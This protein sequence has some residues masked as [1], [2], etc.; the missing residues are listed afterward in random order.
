M[1][2]APLGPPTLRAA[3]Y[4]RMSDKY[5]KYSIE[6][7]A[8]AI[9]A[10][11]ARRNITITRTYADKG[12][13]GVRIVGRHGLQ[14]LIKTV[15]I[16]RA[17]FDCVLVYDISR[18]GR[19][20]D[21]DESAY[22]EFICK[23]AGIRV[24]Y[25][26]DDFENDGSLA[27]I[28]LKN[29]KRLA[30]ADFSRQLS[31]K[32]FLGQCH[33]A[34]LGYW[35][36]GPAPY[37][38]RR[39]L[40]DER[41][42][43]KAVLQAGDRKNLKAQRVVL[44]P[45]PKRE[46]ATVQRIFTLFAKQKWSRTEIAAELNAKRIRNSRGKPWTMLTISNVL[47]NEAYLGH[48]VYNRRSMKL[49][50]RSVRNP[51]DMWVR[52]DN[53][54]APIITPALFAKAQ[55][56]MADLKNGRTRTDEEMLDLLRGL[57]RRE[58]KLTVKTILLAKDVPSQIV[59]ARRF[60]SLSNAYELIGYKPHDRYQF[61]K[62]AASINDVTCKVAD[63][64]MSDLERRGK[65]VTFLPELYLLT[66]SKNITVGI[67]VARAVQDGTN[68]ARKSKRWEVRKIRYRRSDFTLVVRMNSRN[69]AIQDFFFMPTANLPEA[70]KDNRIR[71]SERNFGEFHYDD[72]DGV[73]GAL[74]QRLSTRKSVTAGRI[75]EP[76]GL[77]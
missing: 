24:H 23:Q 43:P 1:A 7:Q 37:G 3:Q 36:G 65:H 74:H 33:V 48:I 11:A 39:L 42:K 59:Y 68:G 66:I 41:G 55:K 49:G 77:G 54:F 52:R 51:S 26:A 53:A 27:S 19:F 10:Y 22:Y 15:Q 75:N 46:V 2:N 21:V 5:Q 4:V 20:L 70:G 28:V 13:S 30:A 67:V 40:V 63:D 76:V 14:E 71:I 34:S 57:L 56:G 29:N 16:G 45:G 9:A 69:S 62:I 6:N 44:V 61:K 17:D 47:K 25:C 72:L 32:V 64:V 8:A 31:K 73:L 35:R 60:G 58:G 38:L 50:E 18:W 12:R